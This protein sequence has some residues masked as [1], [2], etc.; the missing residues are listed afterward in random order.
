MLAEADAVKSI[1]GY[2]IHLNI[3]VNAPLFTKKKQL[4]EELQQFRNVIQNR[5]DEIYELREKEST[6]C[7]GKITFLYILNL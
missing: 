7:S 6:L 5:R 1:L 2:D 3:S 4:N